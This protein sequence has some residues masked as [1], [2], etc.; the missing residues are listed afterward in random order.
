MNS[1]QTHLNLLL[2]VHHIRMRIRR[3]GTE[4][5]TYKPHLS[6]FLA[7]LC[8]RNGQSMVMP[9]IGRTA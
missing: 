3:Y 2:L 8:V 7:H 4:I 9:A 6:A 5:G 1:S